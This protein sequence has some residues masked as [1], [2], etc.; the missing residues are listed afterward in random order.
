MCTENEVTS[1]IERPHSNEM[2][3]RNL[4]SKFKQKKYP[5]KA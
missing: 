1:F 4:F 5:N 3:E 2:V